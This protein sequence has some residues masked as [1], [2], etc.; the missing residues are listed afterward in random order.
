MP[1]KMPVTTATPV[2][3]PEISRFMVIV[4]PYWLV[5]GK[6]PTAPSRDRRHPAAVCLR[7]EDSRGA[8]KPAGRRLIQVVAM[9]SRARV[10]R[11]ERRLCRRNRTG[12]RRRKGG[13]APLRV[14]VAGE[15]G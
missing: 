8:Q 11:F 5:L 4:S 9:P 2:V 13:E 3:Q 6:V 1:A 14:L 7:G 15:I 12:A 10:F